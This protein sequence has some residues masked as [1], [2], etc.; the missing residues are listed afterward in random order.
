MTRWGFRSCHKNW[1]PERI[2]PISME[3]EQTVY[4]HQQQQQQNQDEE[5]EQ[6]QSQRHHRSCPEEDH[7]GD[8]DDCLPLYYSDTLP[9]HSP[10]PSPTY[11][12]IPADDVSTLTDTARYT[13]SR[14]P[15][16]PPPPPQASVAM[17]GPENV[18]V[19]GPEEGNVDPHFVKNTQQVVIT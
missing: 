8:D 18:V 9:P 11:A 1:K 17:V 15:G 6:H 4:Q 19:L 7:E 14:C 16:H 12:N 10:S 2:F 5:E 13:D 3:V